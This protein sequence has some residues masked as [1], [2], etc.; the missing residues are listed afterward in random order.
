MNDLIRDDG[1]IRNCTSNHAKMSVLAIARHHSTYKREFAN[2][3]YSYVESFKDAIP[4]LA[5]MALLPVVVVV[6]PI[7]PFIRAFFIKRKAIK[8]C[9]IEKTNAER[10][11]NEASVG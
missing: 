7:L 4:F 1:K 2:L 5:N 8:E 6:L 9:A 11:A 10:R 3:Q